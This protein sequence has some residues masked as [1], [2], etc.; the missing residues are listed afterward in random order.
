MQSKI[1]KVT[2][3]SKNHEQGHGFIFSTDDGRDYYFNNFDL[4]NGE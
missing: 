4:T 1:K 3:D 2:P